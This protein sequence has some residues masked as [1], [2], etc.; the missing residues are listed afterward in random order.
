[1][2]QKIKLIEPITESDYQGILEVIEENLFKY[3]LTLSHLKKACL[4]EL[5]AA[6]DG[7]KVVGVLRMWRPGEV[8]REHDDKYFNFEKHPYGREHLGYIAIVAVDKEYRGQGIA[9]KLVKKALKI[10]KEWETKAVLVH[11]SKGSPQNASEKL[12]KSLGFESIGLQKSPW[13]EYS[14]EKGPEGFWCV[15]CGNPCKCDQL[16]MIKELV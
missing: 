13:L 16:E 12:F 15:F 8:F 2:V 5:L 7:V 14:K 9:K 11:A 4:G 6:K 10:Q 3:D 1:M